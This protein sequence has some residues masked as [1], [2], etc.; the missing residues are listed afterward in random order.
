MMNSPAAAPERAPPPS[1]FELAPRVALAIANTSA[2]V[3]EILMKKPPLSDS[4]EGS[5]GPSPGSLRSSDPKIS[6]ATEFASRS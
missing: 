2:R 4:N 3:A 5:L 6:K 1:P